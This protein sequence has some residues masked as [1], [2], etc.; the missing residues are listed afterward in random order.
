MNTK[1]KVTFAVV[2]CVATVAGFTA[3]T[4]NNVQDEQTTSAVE[5]TTVTEAVTEPDL[6]RA[7]ETTMDST[8]LYRE[9]TTKSTNG[10]NAGTT[11]R[12]QRRLRPRITRRPI[13]QQPE[14]Q[15]SL[16]QGRRLRRLPLK[17][18][19]SL[20]RLLPRF[21]Q[22]SQ[23]LPAWKRFCIIIPIQAHMDMNRK[24]EL[25]IKIHQAAGSRMYRVKF[26][27]KK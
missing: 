3:C 25:C 8:K 5:S 21:P 7:D 17:R 19:R 16:P 2:A 26:Q 18:Q 12:L 20:R 4:K 24:R 10:T 27:M 23:Q 14:Q 9:S 13:N 15:L 6:I 1:I 11:K 22:Q